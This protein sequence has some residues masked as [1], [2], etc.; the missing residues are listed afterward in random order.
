MTSILFCGISMT[1]ALL[2]YLTHTGKPAPGWWWECD[3]PAGRSR[4]WH[5]RR[6]GMAI[7]GV[8]SAATL[9]GLYGLDPKANPS[10][11]MAYWL[12]VLGML[13]WLMCLALADIR[14]TLKLYRENSA[15][16]GRLRLEELLHDFR[17]G[18][19]QGDSD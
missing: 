14:H 9:L 13:G 18:R 8:V 17:K 7:L 12:I 6:L 2:Y 16:R 19:G 4:R 5:R 3:T 10:S 1:V 15:A 11:F